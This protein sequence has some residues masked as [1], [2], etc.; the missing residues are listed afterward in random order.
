MAKRGLKFK[1]GALERIRNDPRARAFALRKARELAAEAGGEEMGYMVTD[2]V[3]QDPRAAAS[4]MAT[5][6]A[7]FH[8]RKHHSLI[9]SLD[10][11]K[12]V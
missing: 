4:V 8:N 6:H 7:R 5:G 12:E 3:L 1:K 11:V 10:R 9:R 2:R